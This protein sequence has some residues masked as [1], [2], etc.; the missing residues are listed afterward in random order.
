[1]VDT[2]NP[3]RPSERLG[4][5]IAVLLFNSGWLQRRKDSVEMLD[6]VWVRRQTSIDCVIPRA[7]Q[8]FSPPDS[9]HQ[10]FL[11]PIALLPKAPPSLMRFD[12]EGDDGRLSLPRR[13]Q[14]ALASYA[15]LVHAAS[16]ALEIEPA[17]LP[18]QLREE[19][20][21]VAAGPQEYANPVS[22]Y[23]RAPSRGLPELPRVRG[24]PTLEQAEEELD[25]WMAQLIG[26]DVPAPRSIE[27]RTLRRRELADLHE[28]LARDELAS[29]L[30]DACAAASVVLARVEAG[31]RRHQM[32]RL[33]YD[34]CIYKDDNKVGENL[35][36]SFG[37]HGIDL[38]VETPYVGARSYH[39]EF[40][41]AKGVE[42]MDSRLLGRDE[43]TLG[44]DGIEHVDLDEQDQD[45]GKFAHRDGSRVHHYW[46][47]TSSTDQVSAV[48]KLRVARDN[49]VGA[50]FWA[51]T[52]VAVSV[53]VC[54]ALA[55]P[56]V[57][58]GTGASTL[59]LLF[60]G[61]SATLVAGATNHP[62]IARILQRARLALVFSALLA[63]AT[64]AILPF[65]HTGGEANAACWVRVT[66]SVLG[67]LALL[68]VGLL[69]LARKLP[70]PQAQQGRIEQRL[71][72]FQRY[73]LRASR[74][75]ARRRQ[76]RLRLI[77]RASTLTWELTEQLAER[78]P[79]SRRFVVVPGRQGIAKNR[80]PYLLL[81]VESPGGRSRRNPLRTRAR[82]ADTF[83]DQPMEMRRRLANTVLWLDRALPAGFAFEAQWRTRRAVWLQALGRPKTVPP[84]TSASAAQLA[85]LVRAGR[86]RLHRVY[87]V[88]PEQLDEASG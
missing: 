28:R 51:S 56:L 50:A 77:V 40:I 25:A 21:F 13:Q 26:D 45:E 87:V 1:M 32:I 71:R 33:S 36:S 16:G 57:R 55:Q 64:A 68:P 54:A 4:R 72:A 46:T 23:L 60:P 85:A 41:A 5:D 31:P 18:R 17:A 8:P 3:Q 19:L 69:Y 47:S 70:R 49:F 86:A 63:F 7:L 84:Q 43:P 24:V 52:A 39:F 61:L 37:W 38:V 76:R 42:V 10:L 14:N 78:S 80:Q 44:G 65:I 67:V 20:L 15:A 66:W 48:V 62:L 29:W 35:S 22:H 82:L 74:R 88:P 83:L 27:G 6:D 11:L 2:T 34:A 81:D 9:A 53:L 73:V 75:G 59:L 79:S 12:F 58:H 30:L